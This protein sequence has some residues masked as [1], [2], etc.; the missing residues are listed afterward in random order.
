MKYIDKISQKNELI[1]VLILFFFFN[2]Q[3]LKRIHIGFSLPVPA[4][5]C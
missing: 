3:M 2:A 5:M 4:W 1:T